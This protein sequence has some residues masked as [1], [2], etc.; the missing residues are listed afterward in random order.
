[1]N[2]S[3]VFQTIYVLKYVILLKR[4]ISKIKNALLYQIKIYFNLNYTSVAKKIIGVRTVYP[5]KNK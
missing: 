1:M 4:T 3:N 5:G 2:N